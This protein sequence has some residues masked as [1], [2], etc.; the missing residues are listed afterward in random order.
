[1][2][3]N[4]FLTNKIRIVLSLLTSF[5]LLFSFYFAPFIIFVSFIPL[6]FAC[7]YESPSHRNAF[8]Y[9]FI[10]GGIFAAGLLYW[11]LFLDAPIKAWLWLGVFLLFIYFGLVFGVTLWIIRHLHKKSVLLIPIVWTAIEFLRSL[12]NDV[13][14]P[15]GSMGYTI[16]SY[17]PLI[18][19]AEFAG[20][21]GITFFILLINALLFYAISKRK[22][23]YIYLSLA[24]F[25]IVCLQG[26]VSLKTISYPAKLRVG[27]IQ[28]NFMPELKQSEDFYYRMNVLYKLSKT[29]GKCDLLV[30]P[31][32]AVPGYFNLDNAETDVTKLVSSL[33]IPIVFGSGR[34]TSDNVYNSS[35]LMTPAGL[36]GFYDK[37]Y[38][39]P[40][41]ERLPFDNVFPRLRKLGFGQG[42][43]AP[44]NEYKIFEL[45][46]K[47]PFSVLICFESIFPRV[48]RRFV[49]E[50]AKFLVNIT[51]DCWFGRTVAPYQHAQQ[52]ILRA[53]EY[54]IPIIRC[55]N[56]GISYFVTPTGE[57]KQRTAIFTQRV[58]VENISLREGLTFYAKFGDW[59]A[60]LCVIVMFLLILYSKIRI[61]R[62][63]Q[64]K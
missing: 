14:F 53:V 8:K 39:V 59:F 41:G 38:L 49:R 9:S 7:L 52:G 19:S 3:D 29:A 61:P 16:I 1:M 30:W 24:V 25:G 64:N 20:L 62:K 60:W 43:Y 18:Q 35:F 37:Q 48:S 28:P 33:N 23:K 57:L 63:S 2:I 22:I 12:T 11:I 17:L 26:I 40:F 50:G 55:A 32:S 15:W 54:R 45:P 13:G 56:T 42:D 27:I 10:S 51:N 34:Y 31:E 46:D 4:Y 58:I 21:P 44:G 47:T 5:L 6:L 36:N